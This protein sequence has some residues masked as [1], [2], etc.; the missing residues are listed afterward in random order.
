MTGDAPFEV[1][2]WSGIP[3]DTHGGE[4]DGG[5]GGT[6]SDDASQRGTL[7]VMQPGTIA[8][9]GEPVAW[10]CGRPAPH[11]DEAAPLERRTAT[12]PLQVYRE[13]DGRGRFVADRIA[14]IED[15]LTAGL[16]LL[17]PILLDGVRIGRFLQPRD[18][19]LAMQR[20]ALEGRATLPVHR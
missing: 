13:L 14:S 15:D 8:M 9:P 4:S 11:I 17:T 7:A 18:T 5:R 10:W 19:W 12:E 2:E 6:A 3:T 16:P 1:P 20:A